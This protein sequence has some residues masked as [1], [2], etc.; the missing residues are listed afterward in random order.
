M[1]VARS[2][3]PCRLNL[4]NSLHFILLEFLAPNI[5]YGVT[6]SELNS[7]MKGCMKIEKLIYC[8]EV[9]VGTYAKVVIQY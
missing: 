2:C 5:K 1:T 7:H 9:E 8:H 4:F 3:N 6:W